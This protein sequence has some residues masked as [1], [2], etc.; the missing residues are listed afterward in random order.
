MIRSRRSSIPA[1]LVALG[2]AVSFIAGAQISAHG[3]DAATPNP[4]IALV[5]GE[6]AYPDHPLAT[7]AN[8]AGLVA[9]T[10]QAAGFDVVGARDLDE[11]S[12]RI[13]IR[14]FINKS[15]AAGPNGQDFVY[16]AGRGVQYEG[17]NYF[18][19]VDAQLQ[20][21]ADV[22]IEA[23]KV[24]DLTHALAAIQGRAHIVVLDAARANN[25]VAQGPALAPGLALVDPEPNSLIAFN[26]SPGAVAPDE[27][28]SY[29]AY[30]KDLA[31]IMRQGGVPLDDVFEQ[32]RLQVNQDTAGAVIPWSASKLA[33]PVYIFDRAADA[34]PPAV[35]QAAQQVA[36]KPL[37]SFT[38]AQAYSVA[39]ARDT[40]PAYEEY[41]A[42][43][44]ASDQARRVRAIL[45]ARREALFW[46]RSSRDNTPRA[47]WTYLRRYPNGPH[48]ADAQ[49]RL[50]ILSAQFN[51]PDDFAPL[52]YS[53]LPPPPPDEGFYA[54]A[55]VAFF[56]GPDYGPPPPPPPFGF[57]P[58]F[59]D[60]WRDLPPPP[61][62]AA[63]GYLPALAV[64]IPLFAGAV[65]LGRDHFHGDNNGVAPAG[66]PG[67]PGRAG[68]P[69][70]AGAPGI[71]GAPGRPGVPGAPG[72]PGAPGAAAALAPV[73][74]P[75]LPRGVTPTPP[76][77]PLAAAKPIAL[78]GTPGA[79]PVST[80]VAPAAAKP[81]APAAP[82][83][84]PAAKPA[85]G[86]AKPAA[87]VAPA[88]PAV[89]PA[90]AGKPLPVPAAPAAPAAQKP[91][92]VAPVAPAAPPFAAKPAVAVPAAPAA[93]VAPAQPK[94]AVVAPA[95][96]V[97]PKPAVVA[98]AAPV[99]PKPAVVAPAAPVAP[100]PAVVAPAAPKPAIV[101]P[102][103]HAAPPPA[104][105]VHA[106]PPPPAPVVH[107]A[108]PPPAP[109]VHAAPPPA[110]HGPPAGRPVCGAPPLK[111]CPK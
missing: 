61:P 49:R 84:L 23:V 53:D 106:A 70:A 101:A 48:V 26:A 65:I 30:G 59:D 42:T 62:P 92:I 43:Y 75:P 47:Y 90:G 29:G 69:G 60:G 107:A 63:N 87:P 103:A 6:A 57:E 54:D 105:V 7:T 108:P 85:V 22:P 9:Q 102:P 41:V 28:G 77:A 8:D 14:D 10:L 39:L 40:L 79:R 111:P 83:A 25:F 31:G 55:P 104:P 3:Q 76:P 95:A 32:T 56:G 13:A 73:A 72:Q 82:V 110:P 80:A 97:A 37:K 109:V 24:S 71:A 74:P 78:P 88:V 51:P 12:L 20:R 86:A 33:A 35:I 2:A 94:P 17:D 67:A 68:P 38:P 19:P 11:K 93:P 36:H 52:M 64:G 66:I 4:R 81:G 100:K 15:A 91:G 27:T 1:K 46:L 45:A 50:A 89:L 98:P 5:I 16:L 34:P 18:V 44:P 58:V 99:A 96:P 21:D